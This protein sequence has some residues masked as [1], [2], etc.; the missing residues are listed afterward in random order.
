MLKYMFNVNMKDT[1]KCWD[2]LN[3]VLDLAIL[4]AKNKCCSV[5]FPISLLYTI[6]LV[7]NVNPQPDFLYAVLFA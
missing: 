6:A 3:T 5:Y 2:K 1:E 4:N 7:T